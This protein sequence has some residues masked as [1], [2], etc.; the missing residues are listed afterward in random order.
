[1]FEKGDRVQDIY[2]NEINIVKSVCIQIYDGGSDQTVCFE[3]TEKQQTGWNK[4]KNLR[5]VFKASCLIKKGL[6][7][8]VYSSATNCSNGGISSRYKKVILTG[9][10]IPEIFTPNINCPEVVLQID[11]G[12]T[13]HELVCRQDGE[14]GRMKAL[15]VDHE[16]KG[17][18]FGGSFVYSSDSRFPACSPIPLFDR[19]EG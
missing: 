10:G 7:C 18:M 8:S 14:K 1:M 13:G 3:P 16:N 4:G 6:L 2:T 19:F 15:P 17:Y 12:Q 9:S 5:L 11:E